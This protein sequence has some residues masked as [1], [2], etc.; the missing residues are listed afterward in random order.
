[1]SW[2]PYENRALGIRIPARNTMLGVKMANLKSPDTWRKTYPRRKTIA[3]FPAK[4]KQALFP[5]L[6]F[7]FST[8]CNTAKDMV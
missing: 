4:S 6:C 7:I 8:N 1:M 3:Q 2:C 5:D